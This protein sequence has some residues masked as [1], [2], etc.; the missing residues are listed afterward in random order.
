[1]YGKQ[2][3]PEHNPMKVMACYK[4][5]HKPPHLSFGKFVNTFLNNY[6]IL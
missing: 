1:M 4:H 2:D 3:I 6:N 5:M